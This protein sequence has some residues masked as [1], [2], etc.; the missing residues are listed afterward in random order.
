MGLELALSSAL[1]GLQTSQTQL[2]ITSNNVSNAQTPGY[3]RETAATQTVT[4]NGNVAGVEL[5]PIQRNVSQQLITSVRAETTTQ[6][7]QQTLSDQL[8][9][10]QNFFG[11]PNDNTS[12]TGELAGLAAAFQNLATTPS[13]SPEKSQAVASAQQFTQSLNTLAQNIQS[14]RGNADQ[15][16]QNDVT[17][18]AAQ[19][20]TI[21][22][23]NAQ[24]A[25]LQALSQPT[26][27]LQDQR[28]QAVNNLAKDLDVTT[29]LQPDGTMNVYTTSGITLLAGNNTINFSHTAVGGIG[30]T[31][32]YPGAIQG[33]ML[34]GLDVTSKVSG[35]KLGALIQLRDQT[36][37]AL[38]QQLDNLGTIVANN[39]N[40]L[41]NN[42]AS[43][44][45]PNSLTGSA[46]V[47]LTDAF[48]GTGTV[49]IAVVDQNG[50]AVATPL[51]LN[52]ATVAPPTVAGLVAA[53]N[54]G[55][56]ANGTASVTNGHLVIA[57]TGANN[58]IAINQQGT[59]VNG[60][61]TPFSMYYGL[62]DFFTMN[63]VLSAAMTIN[64]RSDIVA[65]PN[66][67]ATGTLSLSA[68]VAGS[69]A[70][71]PGDSSTIQSIA[72]EFNTAVAFPAAG[73][74]AATT[75]KFGDYTSQIIGNAATQS[76][77]ATTNAK[78]QA[79]LLQ[80]LQSKASNFSGVNVDEEVANLT[81]YQNAYSASARVLTIVTQMFNTL[82]SIPTS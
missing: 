26:V 19:L 59:N 27:D 63:T 17:D 82:D 3:S 51:D 4:V 46:T 49:R 47:A 67:V 13:G 15:Q 11:N 45:P 14:L 23:L 68:L 21:Q 18:A 2:Q 76:S 54:A 39:I 61:G 8:S 78:F 74:L 75:T 31:I 52:L 62:N 44:P 65:N 9:Q 70:V 5:G 32:V 34:N 48:A 79:T 50:N 6:A 72:N 30:P 69:P 43:V 33:I 53:I 35:G 80:N 71:A 10:L 42:G 29:V 1:T 22:Q 20:N 41:H 40:A 24:I 37:P 60:S 28:D 38:G 56:G 77:N 73:G 58:G 12:L 57:A 25:Q 7:F 55:L 66:I 16:I 36:L 81:L 64:V